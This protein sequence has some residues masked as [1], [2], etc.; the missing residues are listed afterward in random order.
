MKFAKQQR[1]IELPDEIFST[2]GSAPT[3]IK[4][5]EKTSAGSGEAKTKSENNKRNGK[6]KSD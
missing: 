5:P 1:D 2:S 4:L 3:K 6:N